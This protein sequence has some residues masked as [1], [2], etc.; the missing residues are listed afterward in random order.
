M[1]PFSDGTPQVSQWPIPPLHFFDYEV[2]PGD[3]DAG[4]YFYHSHVNFQAVSVTGPLIVEDK[5][6]WP[7][8]TYGYDEERVVLVSDYFNSTD[9]EIVD[10]LIGAPFK[11]SGETN[12]VLLNGQGVPDFVQK[13][14]QSCALP[15]FDLSPG[16]TYRFRFIGG[17]A[18]SLVSM[19]IQDHENLT[20]I[21]AD[22]R[23]TKPHD[24]DHIQIGTGQ[25]FDILIP[26]KSEAELQSLGRTTFVMQMETKNRPAMYTGFAI[27]RYNPSEVPS[28]NIDVRLPSPSNTYDYLEYALEPASPNGFPA[29]AEVTRRVYLT[30]IQDGSGSAHI[31]WYEN[32]LDWTEDAEPRPLLVDIYQQGQAAIPNYTLALENGGWD[33]KMKAWPAKIGEVL[34]IIIQNTG[35]KVS[36]NGGLDI[37]PFHA[38]AGHYYDIGTGNGTYDPVENEKRLNGYNPVL[39]DTTYLYKFASSAPPGQ[40]AS[41]R[42]WRVRVSVAGAYLIHCH[43]LQHMIMGKHHRILHFKLLLTA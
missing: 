10:G 17:T 25:R 30:V 34:E 36:N 37:H 28:T 32:N 9:A 18:L 7:M 21:A 27:F 14:N 31:R 39:R 40:V 6:T 35:S 26:G 5:T 43:I 1:A 3:L 15:I 2:F 19:R 41:W 33:P 20:V 11:W 12:A 16:K 13:S 38:H 29:A 8:S 22:A 24:I 42:G 4:T 23:Y